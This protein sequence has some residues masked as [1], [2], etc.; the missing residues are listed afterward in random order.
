MQNRIHLRVK[1]FHVV[2][3]QVFFAIHQD[4]KGLL[5]FDRLLHNLQES[6]HCH[7]ASFQNEEP[8]TLHQWNIYEN[9][10]QFDQRSRPLPF[11]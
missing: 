8:A 11:C 6:E 4:R 9:H 5:L 7:R 3:N 2:Q 10:L 1:S